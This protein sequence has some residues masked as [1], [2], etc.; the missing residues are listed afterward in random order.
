MAQRL[1][2]KHRRNRY[3]FSH[4]PFSSDPST[5]GNSG[6]G[7][8]SLYVASGAAGSPPPAINYRRFRLLRPGQQI[9]ALGNVVTGNKTS[10]VA[11]VTEPTSAFAYSMAVDTAYRVQVRTWRDDQEN[12]ALDFEQVFDTDG[13]TDIATAIRGTGYLIAVSACQAGGAR[14]DFAW[15]NILEAG[16]QPTE[17]ALQ[18]QSGPSS[19]AEVT[20]PF[21]TAQ[22]RYRLE[23]A[24]LTDAGAY[25][26][27]IVA[28]N[29][30]T[31]Q[32]LDNASGSGDPDIAITADASGPSAVSSITTEER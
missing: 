29:G 7:G 20:T 31:T 3:L 18:V 11:T 8:A 1:I 28:R 27:H 24:S 6:T 16:V 17:F 23:V 22:R 32:T 13:S 25:V 9:L 2:I 10:R 14:F 15:N 5:A 4:R 26:F 12:P 30:A 21:S 19:P